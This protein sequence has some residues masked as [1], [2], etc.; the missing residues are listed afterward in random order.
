MSRSRATATAQIRLRRRSSS[1]RLDQ[2]RR[3]LVADRDPAEQ[4]A[5]ARVGGGVEDVAGEDDERL[6]DRRPRHQHPGEDEDDREEDRELDRREEHLSAASRR[7]PAWV[8]FPPRASGDAR[9]WNRQGGRR[10]HGR[11]RWRSP[12]WPC[13]P[14]AATPPAAASSRRSRA[15]TS[16]SA[17]RRSRSATRRCCSRSPNLA[18]G[19]YRANARGC[20]QYPE[21]LAL[22]RDLK[23]GTSCRAWSWSRSARTARSARTTSTTRSTSSARS[24]PSAWSRRARPA[25][26]PGTTPSVVRREAHKHE[27]RIELLDWV[28]YSAGHPAWF[29]PDGLHLTFDGRRRRSRGCSTSCSSCCRPPR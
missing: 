25:A 13:A 11:R 29:Q 16:T 20:R 17:A 6:P 19:G 1:L 24:G 3:D 23:R 12:R 2:L 18:D 22:I 8:G 9:S 15:R 4:Q 14:A 10:A 5:E 27:N 7:R 28:K 21:G 26:A